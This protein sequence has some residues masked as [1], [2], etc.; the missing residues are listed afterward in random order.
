MAA[1]IKSVPS[2]A[3]L[4]AAK[5][6][7]L[8]RNPNSLRLHKEA[9][10]S[11]PGGNTRTVLHTAPFPVSMSRGEGYRLYS[12]DG[13]TY[14]DLTAE[15]TAALLGHSHPRLLS[16]IT[17]TLHDTGLSLGASTRHDAALAHA[18]C[19]RFRLAR[20]R[21]C[22]SG[23]EANLHALAAARAHTGRS[24]VVVFAGGYHGGVLAFPAP[25]GIATPSTVDRG[26][27]VVGRFNDDARGV[28]EVV[29]REKGG[30][31]VAAVLVEGMQGAAGCVP[32][33]KDFLLAARE[34]AR[35]AGAVF[36]LDEVMT[37]RMGR[38]GLQGE[39]GLELEP[40]LTTFGKW[41]GGGLA[42]GAFGG[43]EDVMAVFDPTREGEGALAQSGT[44]NNNSLAMRAGLVAL[45]EVFTKDVAEEFMRVGEAFLRRLREVTA[46][47]KATFTGVG[48]VLCLHVTDE[49]VRDIVRAGEIEE[50]D[51]LKD[52]FWM[53]MMEEGFWITRRGMIALILGTPE[54]ELDR[55]VECVKAFLERHRD[56]MAL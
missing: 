16:A 9:A 13:H 39:P 31:D 23:T 52:I 29:M 22:P 43:R 17:S 20:A 37:S 7:F 14:T 53:E 48:T 50:R 8:A 10:L 18:L 33:R 46:G 27:W 47:T 40:D 45:T 42:F 28:R 1:S 25:H 26:R 51:D 3:V 5:A 2:A 15:Y 32:G 41:L 21:F 54:S 38:R 24:K 44:F 11:M 35:E 6:R 30:E 49:G 12:E 36:V 55:F 34:A 19:A 4:E 56:L